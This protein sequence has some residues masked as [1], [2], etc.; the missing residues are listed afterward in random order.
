[1]KLLHT[2]DWHLGK[3]LKG[4]PRLDEQRAV[5]AEIV[6]IAA[7]E[8]VD[9]V[10]VAGDVF[11]SAAPS[12]EAQELA[13]ATLLALRAGGAEVV[14]IAGNHDPAEVFEAVRPVFGAAGITITGRVRA[15]ADGGLLS[16]HGAGGERI[17]IAL[18]PFVSQRRIVRAADVFELDESQR[19]GRYAEQLMRF[20]NRFAD[21][22]SDDAVNVILMHG[23]VTGARFGG[24]EREAQSV[25]DY[26][27][28]A[29]AF[30]ATTSYVA[31]GHLH[32]TQQLP[33]PCPTWYPGAPIAVD[34]GEDDHTPAVLVVDVGVGRP[35]QVRVR[36]LASARALRTV[37][38]TLA[39]LALL[40]PGIERALVRAVVR[41]P[42]RV[43]LAD[44]VR[45]L[46]P[47]AIDIRVEAADRDAVVVTRAS[48]L[49]GQRSSGSLFATYLEMQGI[50]DP[51]VTALFEALADE[52]LTADPSVT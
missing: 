41:E 29:S 42:A 6:S 37:R 28:P 8:S 45:A 25:F 26:H 30:P 47:G 22:F 44:D 2:G 50:A 23:T 9:V 3:V 32:R 4:V 13:W 52:S 51:R 38:G 27:V 35:A 48:R 21:E 7:D 24:G 5:C 14:V 20:V 1:M 43:G 34:F 11:E 33:A 17:E 19:Q 12:P 39:E 18:L 36:A 40:A 10:L 31:L 46:L 15:P 49:D 16:L